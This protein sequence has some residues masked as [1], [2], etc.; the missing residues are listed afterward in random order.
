MQPSKFHFIYLY[1]H[2][3]IFQS[4]N[5][6]IHLSIHPSSIFLS[7][8]PSIFPSFQLSIHPSIH[9]FILPY[10]HLV[11]VSFYSFIH[12]CNH[13]KSL[14]CIYASIHASFYASN[15]QS[16]QPPTHPF[17]HPIIHPSILHLPIHPYIVL[18][19]HSLI[20]YTTTIFNFVPHLRFPLNRKVFLQ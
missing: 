14:L 12:S 8:H 17:N 16:T 5:P 1:I 20:L 13:L 9:P 10:F 2:P 19:I 4:I 15:H 11:D 3:C 7:I 6:S 18:T